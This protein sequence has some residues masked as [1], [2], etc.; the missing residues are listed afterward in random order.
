MLA[1]ESNPF[2]P[3]TLTVTVVEAPSE[4]ET[5]E[6]DTVSAKSGGGALP[7]PGGE[8]EPPQLERI[9]AANNKPG[10]NENE[11]TKPEKDLLFIFR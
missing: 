6:G 7:P 8:L 3:L 1:C 2:E 10:A 4:S 11:R 5:L 9:K